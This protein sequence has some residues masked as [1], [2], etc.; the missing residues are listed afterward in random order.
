MG[1]KIYVGKTKDLCD[2]KWKINFM[3]ELVDVV[4]KTAECGLG[5]DQANDI[6]SFLVSNSSFLQW[7]NFIILYLYSF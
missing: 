3:N 2:D 5:P 7:I 1:H 6:L 4:H